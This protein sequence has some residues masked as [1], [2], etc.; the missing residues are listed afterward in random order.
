MS[1]DR[2]AE[3][4]NRVRCRR[5]YLSSLRYDPGYN[6][7]VNHPESLYY[8]IQ[9]WCDTY[10]R[11]PECFETYDASF[12]EGYLKLRRVRYR[13]R[14]TIPA[15]E[16]YLSGSSFPMGRLLC[17][18]GSQLFKSWRQEVMHRTCNNIARR[19]PVFLRVTI[20]DADIVIANVLV[21]ICIRF[22]SFKC[23]E[24]DSPKGRVLSYSALFRARQFHWCCTIHSHVRCFT[25]W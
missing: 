5:T 7:Q 10:L 12:A 15:H 17:L 4:E 6:W 2:R 8:N 14:R 18:R 21:M 24:S 3:A 19:A 11:S 25:T 23:K 20:V 1:L 9:T 13:K 22:E 16:F